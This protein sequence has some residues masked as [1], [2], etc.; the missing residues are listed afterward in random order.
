[1]WWLDILSSKAFIPSP[2]WFRDEL[3][4]SILIQS[5]ASGDAGFGFCAAGL[6]VTGCWSPSLAPLILNDMFVKELLPITIAVL[7]LTPI[8]INHI[9]CSASDNSGVAFRIN[10][11][12]CRNPLGR[13]LLTALADSL[14]ASRCHIL[15]DWN[16]R[17]QPH[18]V[19]ADELSKVLEP[20]QWTSLIHPS[21]KPW[22][23]DLIV[24]ELASQEVTHCS[25]RVPRLAESLPRHL[26]HTHT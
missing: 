15:A 23:F 19:H 16:N 5:D 6:H 4:S 13:C 21:S 12:S 18:A 24:H 11:G 10:C 26:R 8:Y 22:S 3:Q 17:E 9:F 7:L 2:I 1:M 14:A 20:Y 25:I